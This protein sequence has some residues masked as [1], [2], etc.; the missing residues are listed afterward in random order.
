MNCLICMETINNTFIYTNC[1]CNYVYHSKC[2][3]KWFS[4]NYCCPIC[5]KKYK[6]NKTNIK[7]IKSALFYDSIGHYNR[8]YLQN[9]HQQCY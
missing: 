7:T 1:K 8:F 3:Y 9:I 6:N 5:K 4:I 2:I